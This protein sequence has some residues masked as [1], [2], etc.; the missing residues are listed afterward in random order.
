MPHK[1]DIDPALRD[2]LMQVGTATLSS[3][4]IKRGLRNTFIPR[5]TS[6]DPKH[7]GM[8]G[9]AYTL[10]FI[11]SREDIAIA[12]NMATPSNPQ[13]AAIEAVPPG[14]VLI[15]D[16]RGDLGGGN[17][18]D[19]LIARLR[20]RGVAGIVTDGALRDAEELRTLGFPIFCQG[21][22]APP[23]YC[24][25][26]ASDANR[27]IGCGG[28]PV[29]PGDIIRGDSDGVVVIPP[30]LAADVARDSLEQE[31]VDR[32]VR[33]RVDRG[34]AT[35]GLY[36]PNEPNRAAYQRWIAAGEDDSAL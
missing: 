10:S 17:L 12:A 16:A 18:G 21:F 20:Y 32:Y 33:R 34:A 31:R 19:I 4:L 2:L 23:S 6:V 3:Q 26:M 13:R 29:F 22:A 7:A 25:I 15:M 28:V 27:P 35:A 30:H 36:P 5:V 1:F 24:R 14:H 11:P 8:V 9:P